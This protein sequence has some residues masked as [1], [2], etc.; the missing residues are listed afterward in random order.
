MMVYI[1]SMN[2]VFDYEK[3]RERKKKR[4]KKTGDEKLYWISIEFK[5]MNKQTYGENWY[6]DQ[7][8]IILVIAATLP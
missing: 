2:F 1:Q 3:K 7:K 5:H 6:I 4:W 8:K